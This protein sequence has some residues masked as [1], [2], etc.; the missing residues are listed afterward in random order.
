MSAEGLLRAHGDYVITTGLMK[1]RPLRDL[2]EM[3]LQSLA[4][5][6]KQGESANRC[7]DFAKAYLSLSALSRQPAVPADTPS[8][9]P[10]QDNNAS[11]SNDGNG[12]GGTN[13]DPASCQIVQYRSSGPR[14][15]ATAVSRRRSASPD[16]TSNR[17]KKWSILDVIMFVW[18]SSLGLTAKVISGVIISC[19]L[20]IVYP[21]LAAFPGRLLGMSARSLIARVQDCIQYFWSALDKELQQLSTDLWL[22]VTHFFA[23]DG[24]PSNPFPVGKAVGLVLSSMAIWKFVTTP[25]I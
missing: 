6:R 25:F 21:P 18:P 4:V 14:G 17:T 19:C 9:I 10:L 5:S 20:M 22:W 1:G 8:S 11:N 23:I 2:N 3:E 15:R 24:D 7:R 12:G 16:N 13:S